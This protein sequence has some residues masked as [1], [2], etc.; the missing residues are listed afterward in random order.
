MD[1][2]LN[3]K[4]HPAFNGQLIKRT[5]SGDVPD[6]LCAKKSNQPYIAESK[7]RFSSISFSD[8]SFN[9]WREQ[10]SRISIYDKYGALKK[11]KGYIVATK[12]CTET[13]KSSNK[14]KIFA[15]DPETDGEDFLSED[16][17]GIG[18]G[19]ISIHYS[20]LLSKLGLNI[21]AESL[22]IGFV[23]PQQISFN[24]ALWKCNF[25]PLKEELF[26]GGYFSESTPQMVKTSYDTYIYQPNFLQLGQP[27]PS[28]FGIS[29]HVVRVLRQVCLGNRELL[30]Q[31]PELNDT[32][33]RTSNLA[34]LRDGSI[35]G[36]LDFFEFLGPQTI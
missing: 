8:L 1:K 22:E 6:Y 35:S 29:L 20:R 32:D 18:N 34:W 15:E 31:I 17:N 36:A 33:F 30:S 23:I 2:V 26:I 16:A 24:L 7:G 21:F 13:N 5:K 9:E 28:F 3:K 14:S 11:L 4:S 27:S 10:F 19:C 25:P 12:F